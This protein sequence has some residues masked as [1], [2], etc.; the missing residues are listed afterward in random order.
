MNK[1]FQPVASVF[2]AGHYHSPVVDPRTVS[3]YVSRERKTEPDQI[4]GIE[5]RVETMR[6]L[7]LEHLAFIQSTPFADAAS[8]AN[9][10]FYLGG[11]FPYGDA[12][13]LRMMIQHLRPK[14][15][16]EIGSGYSTACMLD[17][18]DHASLK[19][20]QLTCIEP[21]PERLKSILRSDDA[22]RLELI[23]R[24]VQEVPENIV[25]KLE[26]N[27]I[28]F[29]DSTHVLKTGSD[30]HFE[31][32]HLLPRLKPGVVVHFHDVLYPFEY[33]DKWV[34][35]T[36]YS[37]NEAY[38]LRA[39]LMYNPRFGVIFWN[40]LFAR[41]YRASIQAE[42]STFLKNPGSSIWIKSLEK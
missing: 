5:V 33:P 35:E 13:A 37:W 6:E 34:F 4:A 16:I 8:P 18:A 42:F 21:N 17:A 22:S 11:P 7:W 25:D 40:S 20:L 31:L 30:V 28:L 2:P 3:D 36:N 14:Q 19:D 1:A 27:D 41:K 12:I 26:R 9:R 24:P 38:A 10:Y 32:F 39:F 15:I 29:I 23:V